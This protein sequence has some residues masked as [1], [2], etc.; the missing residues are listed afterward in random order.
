M[1]FAVGVAD[2]VID[3]GAIEYFRGFPVGVQFVSDEQR[4]I[5]FDDLRQKAQDSLAGQIV[6]N[7][8]NNTAAPFDSADHDALLCA[9]AALAGLIVVA[10][11]A[12]ARLAPDV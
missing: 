6:G 8:S 7:P 9:P 5:R 3:Y 1:R 4:A 10:A 12:L 11:I 2:P